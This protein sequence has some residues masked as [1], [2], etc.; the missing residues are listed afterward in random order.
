M[1]ENSADYVR[2]LREEE[3]ITKDGK[4]KDGR[5][6]LKELFEWQESSF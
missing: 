2:S 5:G 4:Q 6:F 3:S 1:T